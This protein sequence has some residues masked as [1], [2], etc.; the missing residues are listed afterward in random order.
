MNDKRKSGQDRIKEES[1][2][3]PR[4]T[5]HDGEK[6]LITQSMPSANEGVAKPPEPKTAIERVRLA[7]TI[8]TAVGRAIGDP[9]TAIASSLFTIIPASL[10]YAVPQVFDRKKARARAWWDEV[11]FATAADEGAAA[12]IKARLDNDPHT[13]DVIM[14]GFRDAMEATTVEVLP[15]IA[16]LTREYGRT[17]RAPDRFFRG[18]SRVLVNLVAEEYEPLRL[19]TQRIARAPHSDER[20]IVHLEIK[21]Q[22]TTPPTMETMEVACYSQT[23]G[24]TWF[25]ETFP[26]AS[27]LFEELKANGLAT[28][29]RGGTWDAPAAPFSMAMSRE[30]AARIAKILPPIG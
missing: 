25:A 19:L 21:P 20:G 18:L 15:A 6:G 3:V 14:A 17:G 16:M 30:T 12:E 27:R 7:I 28:E 26:Y 24:F 29:L 1:R 5:A 10:S 9:S 11:V 8:S 22:N 4:D 23:A 2:P 13:Q